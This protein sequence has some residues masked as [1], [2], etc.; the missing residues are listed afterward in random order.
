MGF[1]LEVAWP[2]WEVLG[3]L[4]SWELA[5]G[6]EKTTTMASSPSDLGSAGV[7]WRQQVAGDHFPKW[8]REGSST[9]LPFWLLWP[10]SEDPGKTRSSSFHQGC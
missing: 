8:D 5:R 9:M 2:D 4:S 3:L 7:W 10:G 1:C 6:F